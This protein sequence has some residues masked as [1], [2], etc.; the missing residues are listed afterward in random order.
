VKITDNIS[1]Y[2]VAAFSTGGTTFQPKTRSNYYR[3]N[4]CQT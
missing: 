4:F 1:I 3:I 2:F